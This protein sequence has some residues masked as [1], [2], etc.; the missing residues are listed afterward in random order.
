MPDDP[1]IDRLVATAQTDPDVVG[2]VLAGSSA[3][4]ERRDEWSDHDFLLITEDG[5]PERYRTDLSWLPDPAGIALWFRETPHGLKVLYRSGLLVEFAVFD[6]GEFAGCALNHYAVAVDKAG[7]AE[8]AA[9]IQGRSLAPSPVDRLAEF[10]NFLCL[11]YIAT[12]RARRG[13]RLSA[14]AFTRFY[15]TEHLLRLLRDLLPADRRGQLDKLDVWRRFETAE[16]RI[17]AGIDAA[18]ARPAE[19][20]ARALL[21]LAEADLPALWPEFPVDEARVVRGLLGW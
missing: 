10:R 13:E 8:A 5:T 9:G 20:A 11:V 17:A 12:G 14:N 6:R 3:Q 4:V 2:L 21:D 18:L 19:E 16:P 7:I 1:F 15:A